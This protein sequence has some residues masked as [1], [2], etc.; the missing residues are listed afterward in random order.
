MSVPATSETV[1]LLVVLTVLVLNFHHRT[2]EI[3][4]MSPFIRLVFLNWL[5]WILMMKR[6]GRSFSRRS[7]QKARELKSMAL[8]E[9]L[10]RSLMANVLDVDE[11]P[12]FC[13]EKRKVEP[14]YST[15]LDDYKQ[16]H[17]S[18][19]RK[20][21]MLILKELRYITERMHKEDEDHEIIV[22]WK[23]AAMVIDRL[24]LIV[25]TMFLF[26]GTCAIIFAAPH[27]VA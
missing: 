5:P 12:V 1:P 8:H 9:R 24:C 4:H 6:P 23:F 26:V 2:G 27:V 15:P 19:Y 17:D 22:D 7:V 21:L 25:F 18:Q 11:H 16:R 13:T 10:S 3:Y 14:V 20:E